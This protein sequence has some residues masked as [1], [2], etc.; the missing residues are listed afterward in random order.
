MHLLGSNVM[1]GGSWR[2]REKKKK[3]RCLGGG[4]KGVD[5]I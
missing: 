1:E 4:K 5:L 2:T 3:S